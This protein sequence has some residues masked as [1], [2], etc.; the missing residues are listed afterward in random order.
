ME[1]NYSLSLLNAAHDTKDGV[2]QRISDIL[3]AVT[4]YLL[5]LS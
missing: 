2:S 1:G 5:E 3:P 4:H